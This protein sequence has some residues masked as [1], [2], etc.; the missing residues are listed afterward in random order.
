[1]VRTYV[2]AGIAALAVALC[3]T[4]AHAAA[5]KP[6]CGSADWTIFD[7]K[8]G[9]KIFSG[10]ADCTKAQDNGL[11]MSYIKGDGVDLNLTVQYP[12]ASLCGSCSDQSVSVTLSGMTGK[13][14]SYTAGTGNPAPLGSECTLSVS[15]HPVNGLLPGTLHAVVGACVTE[16]GCELTKPEQWDTIVVNGSFRADEI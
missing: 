9:N 11:I 10:D 4:M 5:P 6:G 13:A 8:T 3:L 7:Q 16:G 14:T 15:E 2:F 1:M 12:A